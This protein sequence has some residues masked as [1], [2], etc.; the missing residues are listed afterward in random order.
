MP[1]LAKEL[2]EQAAR[3]RTYV[4]RVVYAVL[5]LSFGLLMF[6]SA[7]SRSGVSAWGMLGR[8]GRFSRR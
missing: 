2:T 3:T 8:G 5:V 7:L 4:L 6:A 1:L